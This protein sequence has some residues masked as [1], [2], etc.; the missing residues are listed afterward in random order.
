MEKLFNFLRVIVG[1]VGGW[2][3]SI[4]GAWDVMLWSL[5]VLIILDYITGLIKACYTKKLSSEIGFKGLLKK[6][7]ILIVVILANV[8]QN[9][10]GNNLPLREIVIM[11]FIAN[12]GISLLENIAEMGV[13]IP[14]PLRKVLLQLRDKGEA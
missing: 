9:L 6:I 2:C 1:V 8:M 11:F 4:F 12:E 10:M 3:G 14:E 7:V 13:K 5:V